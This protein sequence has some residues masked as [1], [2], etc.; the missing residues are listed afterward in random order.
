MRCQNQRAM[1]CE[2]RECVDDKGFGIPVKS[3]RN[4]VKQYDRTILKKGTRQPQTVTLPRRERMPPRTE[5]CPKPRGQCV[6]K[7]AE[8]SSFKCRSD[9]FVRGILQ[10]ETDVFRERC[11]KDMRLL[12]DICDEMRAR[13]LGELR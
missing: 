7:G 5:R 11:R 12:R 8:G 13:F 2:A 10:P 3:C 1:M 6:Q 9:G 4:L